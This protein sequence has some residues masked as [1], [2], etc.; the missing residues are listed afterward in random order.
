MALLLECH[1]GAI[2][3]LDEKRVFDPE[4]VSF[5]LERAALLNSD[6]DAGSY[7]HI[8]DHSVDLCLSAIEYGSGIRSK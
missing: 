7:E 1:C 3:R 4:E 8:H 2:D 5:D 6:L